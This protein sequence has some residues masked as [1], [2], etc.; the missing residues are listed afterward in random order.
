[1][2]FQFVQLQVR[3]LDELKVNT[4]DGITTIAK[5]LIT[6]RIDDARSA[7]MTT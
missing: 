7:F 5:N 2:D 4:R 1:M 3:Q 6:Y